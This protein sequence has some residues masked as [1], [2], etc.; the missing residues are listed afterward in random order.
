MSTREI[1]TA[2]P[3]APTLEQLCHAVRDA[4]YTPSSA[5]WEDAEH[6]YAWSQEHHGPATYASPKLVAHWSKATGWLSVGGSARR[7]PALTQDVR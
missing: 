4:G 7:V 1:V 3:D 5:C 2:L 6:A